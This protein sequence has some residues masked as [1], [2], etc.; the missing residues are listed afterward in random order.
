MRS[1]SASA[2]GRSAVLSVTTWTRALFAANDAWVMR[3]PAA[4]HFDLAAAL[5]V[6]DGGERA[7]PGFV[8]AG[9]PVQRDEGIFAAGGHLARRLEYGVVE[10]VGGHGELVV[11]ERDPLALAHGERP[12]AR[13]A[14]GARHFGRAHARDGLAH[15]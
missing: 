11:D 12:R 10:R 1:S 15:R 4:H 7:G 2:R 3:L 5:R 8:L 13:V 9:A 6:H 14:H